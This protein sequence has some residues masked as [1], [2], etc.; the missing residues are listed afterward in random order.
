LYRVKSSY[1][2]DERCFSVVVDSVLLVV[3]I[4]SLLLS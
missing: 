2:A 1:F 3:L 4:L